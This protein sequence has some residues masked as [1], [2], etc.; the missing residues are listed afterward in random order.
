ME[1]DVKETS[2]LLTIPNLLTMF[3]MLLIPVF[4]ITYYQH[5]ERRWV[6]MLIFVLAS[7]T[8]CADGFLARRLNQITSFG[9]L[10]DP[11]ADKL[12]ILSMLFCLK[13]AELLVPA[14]MA[15]YND[16]VLYA[17]LG[18]EI[19]M[20]LGASYM[21]KRGYVVHSNVFGKLST[22]LFI[23]GIVMIFPANVTAPWHGVEA[24]QNA[25][26]WIMLAGTLITFAA[27][28]IYTLDSIKLLRHKQT[29]FMQE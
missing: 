13:D 7:I 16:A 18:K 2:R 10:V 28:V 9:K 17:I 25:G 3:R 29:M 14:R 5:P 15:K 20:V 1:K 26:R 11:L 19:F 24:V 8:D 23:V 21:L 4:L 12:M 6:S 22:L 27:L